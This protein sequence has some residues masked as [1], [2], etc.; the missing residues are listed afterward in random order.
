MTCNP[1]PLAS[2]SELLQV[3][4]PAAAAIAAATVIAACSRSPSSPSSAGPPTQPQMQQLQQSAVRFAQ[5]HAVA[6]A[7]QLARPAPP[8]ESSSNRS[9]RAP[10][11]S[12]AARSAET[13]CR[14]LLPGGGPPRQSAAH[15][16]A[17]TVAAL[18]F[19]HCLRS[20]GLP[21]FPDPTSSGQITHETLANAGINLHQ[22]A[23]L[24]AADAC[25]SV[26]H[27]VLTKAAVARFAANSGG[28]PTQAQ[29]QQGQHDALRFAQCMRSH[30]LANFPDPTSPEEFKQS[31]SASSEGSP[32]FQSAETACSAPADGRRPTTPERADKS[33]ADR[34][35]AGVRS[36]PA[37]P[38]V[39]QLPR[40]DEQR[41]RITDET[42]ANAGS[43][44]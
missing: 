8:P 13:A 43:Q 9:A 27:G 4:R 5:L 24:Q 2:C 11:R 3:C 25:V 23:V 19:A 36:L 15:S 6:R 1:I 20:H 30:A 40:P 33:S 35:G 31:I 18:A 41:N 44:T 17:Q 12:P 21:N 7:G 38:R 22:P 42:L 29:M 10:T 16:Q 32:A 34:R 39:P 28:H 37:Q 14:H 26:T